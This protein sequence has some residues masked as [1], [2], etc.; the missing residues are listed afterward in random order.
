MEASITAPL[1]AR[2]LHVLLV[3]SPTFTPKD[4]P[5]QGISVRAQAV[6]VMAAIARRTMKRLQSDV[7]AQSARRL[8]RNRQTLHDLNRVTGKYREVRV[9]LEHSCSGF[10][11][12]SLHDDVPPQ[13]VLG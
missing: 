6:R 5:S 4:K 10:V 1:I 11:R 8:P 13:V 3:A 2:L 9:F 12:L 7:I